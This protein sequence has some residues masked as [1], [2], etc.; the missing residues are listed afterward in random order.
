[1]TIYIS[2]G[3]QVLKAPVAGG[4]SSVVAN[5]VKDGLPAALALNGTT[6]IVYPTTFNGDVDAPLLER[7]PRDLRHGRPERSGQRHHDDLPAPRALA[8][9]AVPEL[10]RRHRAATP[11]GSTART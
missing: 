9:R 6:N 5:E 4:A 7:D 2:L 3:T 8:G 10:H 11:T 1:M